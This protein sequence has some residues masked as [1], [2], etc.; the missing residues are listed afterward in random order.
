MPKI[1]DAALLEL[2]Q[3]WNAIF[4]ALAEGG[5]VSPAQRLR[6]EG[7]MEAAVVLGYANAEQLQDAM[8]ESYRLCSQDSLPEDW[9]QLFPF[10]QI[11]GFG[12]RAPVVPST[13]EQ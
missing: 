8:A 11:P 13:N 6:A 4:T 10:P 7:F 2:E 5:E 9:R 3:R 12:Q 1:D